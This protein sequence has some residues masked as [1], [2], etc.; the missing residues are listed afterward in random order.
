MA[1]IRYLGDAGEELEIVIGPENPD[2]MVGRHRTC[3]IRTS[4]PSVS[5]QHARIFFDGESYWLQDN[6]S[7]NGT[8]YQNQRLEAQ[9]PV[10]V[11]SG[12]ALLC[13]NFEMAFTYDAD[14]LARG[15]SGG[16]GGD[17]GYQ[18]QGQDEA[19]RFASADWEYAQSAPP[20]PP[21]P[22]P[23]EP[24]ASAPVPP[25]PEV[26]TSAPLPPPLARSTQPAAEN[27]GDAALV[28]ELRNA[29]S[30]H[31]RR[32][33]ELNRSIADRDT[34]IQQLMIELES[35]SRRLEDVGSPTEM[36]QSPEDTAALN[37]EIASLDAQLN[38]Q[39]D[40]AAQWQAE[41]QRV[42]AERDLALARLTEMEGVAF[43]LRADLER[44]QSAPPAA[45]AA[46][47]DSA[48][49]DEALAD[50]AALRHQVAEAQ[51]QASKL[52]AGY[53]EAREKFEEARAGRRNAEELAGLLRGRAEAAEARAQA[54]EAA[55]AAAPVVVA[56]PAVDSEELAVAHAQL[57]A[58][59]ARAQET[60]DQLLKVQQDAADLKEKLT[61]AEKRAVAAESASAAAPVGDAADAE[62][63]RAQVERLTATNRELEASA[64][65]N[66]KRIQKL[67]RDAEEA[68]AGADAGKADAAQVGT[69]QAEIS[70]LQAQ[71]GTLQANQGSK[72]TP[73]LTRLVEEL[74]DVVSNFRSDFLTVTDAVEQLTSE[75][76]NER[77]EAYGTLQ[78]GLASCTERTA[79]LKN[80]VLSLRNSVGHA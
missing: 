33:E 8:F 2:V 55:S 68:R 66:M 57:K 63:L 49:L 45:I 50:A 79:V 54:A 24:R 74:N 35:V 73:E 5:R 30:E 71:I 59:K 42:E 13:G 20:P 11:Q 69:L 41:A 60:L 76:D 18:D 27:T 46:P 65:A 19:T 21:P 37:A 29:V 38:E 25:P 9:V 10:Q 16:Y 15:T 14:D 28:G 34:R 23:P 61:A 77:A 78:D 48:E 44:A 51:A 47:V 64:S 6:G 40:V 70:A 12:E 36:V 80:L 53:D 75:D 4:N 17:Y 67:L 26:R 22:P 39:I 56:A 62:K 72:P 58:E 52:Q 31:L 7:S 1:V 43:G 32:N 3:S